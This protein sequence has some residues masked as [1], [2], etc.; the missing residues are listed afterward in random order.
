MTVFIVTKQ[1]DVLFFLF[2]RNNKD[3]GRKIKQ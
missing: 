3:Q 2:F 1:M